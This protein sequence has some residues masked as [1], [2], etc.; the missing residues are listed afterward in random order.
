MDL[1]ATL[2]IVFKLQSIFRELNNKNVFSKCFYDQNQNQ[3]FV[4]HFNTGRIASILINKKLGMIR[5]K[6]FQ[7]NLKH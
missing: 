4:T 1:S 3:I 7:R 6:R 2:P 5:T